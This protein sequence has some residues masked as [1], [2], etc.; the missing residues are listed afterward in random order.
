MAFKKATVI[1]IWFWVILAVV[2]SFFLLT[3]CSMQK[4]E[5]IAATVEDC[6][7]NVPFSSE[8]Q[9]DMERFKIG[10][11]QRDG[12]PAYY[13]Q[14]VLGDEMQKWSYQEVTQLYHQ[15]NGKKMLEKLGGKKGLQQRNDQCLSAWKKN[16]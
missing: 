11:N 4:P 13:C 2:L 10:E 1:R 8:W 3:K 16:H 5:I 15:Q 7:K 6:A 12:L 14:C 9:Q